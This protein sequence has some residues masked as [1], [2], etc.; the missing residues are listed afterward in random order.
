MQDLDAVSSFHSSSSMNRKP[1][2][3][4]RF[5]IGTTSIVPPGTAHYVIADVDVKD[6]MTTVIRAG[7][8]L[9]DLGA[10]NIAFFPTKHGW[11]IYTDY[12]TSWKN[13]L[14]IL[15]D[16]PGIDRNW[17]QIGKRRGYL[18]LADYKAVN[19]DWPLIRMVINHGNPSR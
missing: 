12:I 7:D 11:H 13:V 18:Y 19:L 1:K 3:K 4:W 2:S 16:L 14:K 10:Q 8:Y 5:A 9:Y 15:N 17:L 6:Y